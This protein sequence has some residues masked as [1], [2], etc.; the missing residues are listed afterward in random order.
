MRL[1]VFAGTLLIMMLCE[2][3]LPARPKKPGTFRHNV[4][5]LALG[6]MGS[7]LLRLMP[8]VL[9]AHLAIENETWEVGLSHALGIDSDSIALIVIAMITLDFAIYWQHRYFHYNRYFW[10][11][12]R[13]H[14]SDNTL[15]STSA[16]RFH[17]IEI[18]ISMLIKSALVISL[19]LPFLAVVLFEILLNACAIFNHTNIRLPKRLERLTRYLIVTPSMHR[20]HHSTDRNDSD[21]NFGFCLSIWDRMF[22]TYSQTNQS[23]RKGFE[24]GVKGLENRQAS[25]IKNL[26]AQPFGR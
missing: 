12:H 15:N 6:V 7:L 23:G 22:A 1:A 17:P 8:G 21:S 25:G 13:V 14:H 16:L 2:Q 11:L 10:K 26:L 5:N 3:R 18:M 9:A 4:D 20:I 19:G 24:M